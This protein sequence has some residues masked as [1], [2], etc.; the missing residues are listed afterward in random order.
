MLIKSYATLRDLLGWRSLEYPLVAG[1]TVG[2]VLE[3]L[4][5]EHPDFGAKLWDRG[6]LLT[7]YIT[8]LLNG[9]SVEYLSG[10]ATPVS[11]ADTLSLFPPV[12]GGSA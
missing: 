6:G 2:D 7:G 10:L 3:A 8:V 9:R 4:A 1:A 11:D 12:G 5:H